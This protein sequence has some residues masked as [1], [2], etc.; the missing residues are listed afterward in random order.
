MLIHPVQVGKDRRESRDP[1]RESRDSSQVSDGR[2]MVDD[3]KNNLYVR[4]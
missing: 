2:L 3:L 4:L 1:P